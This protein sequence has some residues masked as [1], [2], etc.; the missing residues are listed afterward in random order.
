MKFLFPVLLL[1]AVLLAADDYPLGPDSQPQP[2]VPK[3]VVTKYVLPPGKIY[4]GTP[5]N[6][7]LYIAAKY[8]ASKPTAFMIFLDGSGSVGN[9]QRVPVVFDNLIAKSE[10]PPLIG[11]FIDPGVMPPLSPQAMGRY[12]RIY[13]YDSLGGRYAQFLEEEMLPE[14]AKKYNL[15]KNP[16]DHAIAG[17]STGAVGAFV[18][19]WER[20]DMFHRVLSFIGTYVSL[21]GADSLPAT[22]RRTEPKPIR[23]FLQ[24]GSN[25]HLAPGQPYGTFYGGSWPLNNQVMYE[26]MEFAGYDAKLVIGTGAH[27]MKQGGAIMPEALR[28]L[29]RDYPKPIVAGRPSAMGQPGWD[30]RGAPYGVIEPGK[31]WQQVG[32][33]YKSVTSPAGDKQGNVFFADPLGNRIYKTDPN[34]KVTVFKNNSGGATALRFG[35]DGMLYASQP[36]AKRIVTYGASGEEKIVAQ[37]VSADDLAL[38]AKNDI[39][40]VDTALKSVGLLRAGSK[41]AV[42]FP[43]KDMLSP[44]VLTLSPDHAL[45]DIGDSQ[46]RFSWSFQLGPDGA[47][48]N[49]EPFYR[50]DMPELSRDSHVAGVTVDEIGQAYFATG[51]GIQFCEQNGRCAGI[52]SKPEIAGTLSNIAFCGPNLNWLYAAEGTKLFRREVKSKG[53]TAWSP[54]TPP[55][56]PL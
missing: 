22:I 4:P 38:T 50:V 9:G 33:T 36:A 18:A 52:L 39:Y 10:L 1:S 42:L 11:I 7:Q 26:A 14:I 19:A 31:A 12:N 46:S 25:D 6:Y 15:S 35:A 13:E 48:V 16:D 8:D 23:F 5:H 44:A 24:D 28:W 55:R 29:W 32:E 49:G 41:K 54:V 30:P 37:D 20:P 56:P 53:V 47:P 43:L 34:G 3:G 2:N 27:D 21:K 17:V 51:L 45:L 40:F